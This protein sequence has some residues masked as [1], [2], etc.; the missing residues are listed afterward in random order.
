MS[1]F[2]CRFDRDYLQGHI[3]HQRLVS[4]LK[5]F[6]ALKGPKQ[7]FKHSVLLSIFKS[8]LGQDVKVARLAF[9]CVATFKIPSVVA[10]SDSI[11]GLLAKGGLKEGLLKFNTALETTAIDKENRGSLL[12]IVT[13]ILFGRLSARSGGSKSSK[14]SPAARRAAV[15]SFIAM[16]CESED[17]LYPFMYLMVR[18][19]VPDRSLL[20]PVEQQEASTRNEI[21]QSVKSVSVDNVA[22]LPTQAHIGFL[23]LLEPVTRQLGHRLTGFVDQFTSIVLSLC[24]L[25]E[26][27]ESSPSELEKNDHDDADDDNDSG[28]EDDV[29]VTNEE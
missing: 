10:F 20:I 14:D 21:L 8:L 28:E 26:V 6:A 3:V 17:D 15:L 13:R 24:K 16:L 7:L 22:P 25:A 9:S 4:I 29:N 1:L 19:Y 12:P 18:N 5:V 27:K 23:Y 11:E 2:W